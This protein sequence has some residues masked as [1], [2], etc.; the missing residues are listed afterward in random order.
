M[1]GKWKS[2]FIGGLLVLVASAALAQDSESRI[3][4]ADFQNQTGD[5]AYDQYTS[6]LSEAIGTF[7]AKSGMVQLVERNRIQ[8][9]INEQLLAQT[10]F[11]DEESAAEV[12]RL[13]G[14]QTMILGSFL[15]EG[16]QFQVNARMIDTETGKVLTAEQ[17]SHPEI[18]QAADMVAVGLLGQLGIEVIETKKSAFKRIGRWV[19]L[20]VGAGAGFGSIS[21]SGKADD[22]YERYRNAVVEEEI[23]S[24]FSEAEDNDSQSSLLAG[25]STASIITAAYL[26]LTSRQPD[27]IYRRVEEE[28]RTSLDVRMD[29]RGRGTVALRWHF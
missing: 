28:A 18:L 6:G 10:G 12:G 21:A 27:R 25:V 11:L 7:I 2:A 13:V 9:A 5:A 29:E 20:G 8:E 17:A 24:S 26:Y 4:L 16:G 14:A 1:I 15:Q 23:A 3:A 19:F 22:A